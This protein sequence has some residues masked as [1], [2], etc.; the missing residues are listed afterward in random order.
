MQ[1]K[2]RL[3]PN[4]KPSQN[5]ENQKEEMGRLE[6]V[7]ANI[8]QNLIVPT[9]LLSAVAYYLGWSVNAAYYISFRLSPNF[10]VKN[11]AEI[12]ASAWVEIALG[13]VLIFISW[14][15][16]Q[17]I[18]VK[19]LKQSTR[20][21]VPWVLGLFYVLLILTLMGSVSSIL[22]IY[23]H[24]IRLQYIFIMGVSV[25]L[26]WSVTILGK[27]LLLLLHEESRGFI[28]SIFKII[29]PSF[30]LYS[31]IAVFFMVLFLS[32]VSIWRGVYLAQ[33]DLSEFGHLYD[34]TIT[35]ENQLAIDIAPTIRDGMF[36]YENLKLIDI[37]EKYLFILESSAMSASSSADT[38]IIPSTTD[39]LYKLEK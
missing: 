33:R 31:A 18:Q 38:Y 8:L 1:S 4:N 7:L 9:T 23:L 21:R 15:L 29:Y 13:I 19:M 22:L 26:L 25:I 16:H 39:L 34:I 20:D 24:G 35:S 32:R 11:P 3:K 28:Y 2:K 12:F 37:N 6:D 27:N 36:V 30:F 10:I 17:I 14:A 5:D